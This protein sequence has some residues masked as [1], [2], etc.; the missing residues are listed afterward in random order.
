VDGVGELPDEGCGELGVLS[1]WLL[2]G[3]CESMASCESAC[4]W[5]WYCG[6]DVD[7]EFRFDRGG[8][9]VDVGDGGFMFE[10]AKG[11]PFDPLLVDVTFKEEI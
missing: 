4:E 5:K 2:S 3:V 10:F 9:E 1:V 11:G 8:W 7:L 6:G